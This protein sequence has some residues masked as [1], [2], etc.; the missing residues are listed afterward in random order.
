MAELSLC[1]PPLS[2]DCAAPSAHRPRKTRAAPPVDYARMNSGELEGVPLLE[3]GREEKRRKRTPASA[4]AVAS[5]PIPAPLADEA[6]VAAVDAARAGSAATSRALLVKQPWAGMLCR[7]QKTWELRS[8]KTL[9]R[10]R[11]ALVASGTGGFVV[12]GATLVACHGPLSEAQLGKAAAKHRVPPSCTV[13]R[14]AQ[15]YAWEFAD[16]CALEVPLKYSHPPGAIIWVSLPA[17][18]HV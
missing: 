10:G 7:G 12:G 2:V 18:V 1:T 17:A 14:Y 11:V 4:V 8:R 3:E 16:A 6:A 13:G 15:T 9:V 5:L